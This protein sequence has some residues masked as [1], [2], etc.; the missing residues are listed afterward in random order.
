MLE[1]APS[2]Y[3]ALSIKTRVLRAQGDLD[4]AAA[5]IRQLLQVAPQV[6]FRYFDLGMILIFQGDYKAA[7]NNMHMAKQR[8]FHNDDLAVIDGY[9]AMMLLATGQYADAIP[10]RA[11]R[12][13]KSPPISALLANSLVDFDRR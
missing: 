8:A 6:G 9:I 12:Q 1:L 4:G 13:R 7:L 3:N 2:D 5:L 11:W 10:Q